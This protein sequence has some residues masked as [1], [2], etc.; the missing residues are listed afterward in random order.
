MVKTSEEK[1]LTKTQEEHILTRPDTYIGSLECVKQLM[2]IFENDK[3]I[4]KT[5]DYIPGLYKIFD[6]I[7]VNARD[8]LFDDPLCNTIKVNFFD[9]G[10]VS[11]YNN[12]SG[13]DTSIHGKEGIHIPELIFTKL[14]SSSNYDDDEKR[15]TGG[16]NGFGAKLTNIFSKTFEIEIVD[17]KNHKHYYQKYENNK[18][19]INPPVIKNTTIKN[20]FVKITFLPD[21]SKFN[22]E[23]LSDTMYQLFIKRVYDI[24]GT[25]KCSV[26][27]NDEKLPI[28]NFK[29]YIL[30]YDF[31]DKESIVHFKDLNERW[32]IAY[33]H[34]PYTEYTNI[35]FVNGICTYQGGTHL[36]AVYKKIFEDMKEKLSKKITIE[37]SMPNILKMIK[38]H[39]VIFLNC[40]II[41]PSFNSQIKETL[42]T[43]ASLFD[44]EIIIPEVFIKKAYAS[45]IIETLI[46]NSKSIESC[47]LKKTDGKKL[48]NISGIPKLD[49]ANKAGTKDAHKCKL[50][51]T[52]GDSAKTLAISG[53]SVVG[54]DYYGVFPLK[55][56]L[57]N[58]R[59]NSISKIMD[60]DEITNIK[61]IVGL[62][63]GTKYT[64][65]NQ[66]RYG[67]IIIMTDADADGSHI[68]GLIINFIDVFWPELLQIQPYFVSSI[69]T[70]IVKIF[71]PKNTLSFYTMCEYKKWKNENSDKK[72]KIKYYKGL[73][74]STSIEAKEYFKN[75]NNT[76]ISYVNTTEQDKNSLLLGFDDKYTDNRKEWLKGY[77]EDN[78][79]DKIEPVMTITDFIN[80]ELIQFSHDDCIRSIPSIYDGLKPSQRKILYTCFKEKIFTEKSEIRVSQ[81]AGAVSKLTCYHHGE[82]SLIGA[83]IGMAQNFVGSN[84]INILFPSGQFGSR[85]MGG[86][87]SASPRYIHTYLSSITK[88]IFREED[89][90]ILIYNDDD[91]VIVEPKFYLPIIPMCLINGSTGIGTGYSTH[92]PSF[93]PLDIVMLIK[94]HLDNKL[95]KRI[96]PWFK[97]FAG[98]IDKI[99]NKY[100]IS[101]KCIVYEDKIKIIE[102]PIGEWT[103]KY[104]E[105]LS[106]YENEKKIKYYTCNST[107]EKVNITIYFNN[108][109]ELYEANKN[110][111]I[112]TTFLKL[113]VNIS[114][115][116]LTLYNTDNVIT[117]YE[118]IYDIIEEF[119]IKRLHYYNIRKLHFLNKYN[120]ELK[121][122][123][124]KINFIKLIINDT[125]IIKNISKQL[126][127]NKLEEL[128]FDSY[129]ES[130]DYLIDM[131]ISQLTLERIHKLENDIIKLQDKIKDLTEKSPRMLW[132]NELKEFEDAYKKYN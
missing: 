98:T 14:L 123:N 81:L 104:K 4:K 24:A 46:N 8:Q 128:N 90:E 116:N 78:T 124:N 2:Y 45:G 122:L 16:R 58:V 113:S 118:S 55:G 99:G 67:N 75:L 72:Y 120:N 11:V 44:K 22:C 13:I 30:L 108:E 41:N 5:I 64:D 31:V 119:C 57:M 103:S 74:T 12:G 38:Q 29:S 23:T 121:Y 85:L 47:K 25:N 83:I 18:S 131:P 68:K 43:K 66:L 127:V 19:I 48:S 73:G 32:E 42:D 35:S 88:F 102:L 70:P 33:I 21:Y 76:L 3:I 79:I 17:V 10:S 130:F 77:N 91:G 27:L 37:L 28:T 97:G 52:E 59:T 115:N 105:M 53:L 89:E 112:E 109:D 117:Q 114:Y 86:K 71:A 110:N 69:L 129:N 54:R 36:D 82:A 34:S 132:L 126:I 63:N 65:V 100:T 26:Y 101:G 50:I 60:N 20:G 84:N 80:K 94:L 95:Y 107:E 96:H 56:K 61:K 39:S 125:I 15:Y 106:K 111:N 9:D 87:D 6:E 1:Y 40:L 93:N 49:D 92:I 7:I 62:K 51:L